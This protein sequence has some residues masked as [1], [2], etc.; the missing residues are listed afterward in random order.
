MYKPAEEIA[1]SGSLC[2]HC[3]L[4]DG[5]KQCRL[6]CFLLYKNLWYWNRHKM[7]YL[8]Y[9]PYRL[10]KLQ[11]DVASFLCNDHAGVGDTSI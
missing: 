10:K 1:I 9:R 8:L 5:G 3:T 6:A 4:E 7:F 2:Y 11:V